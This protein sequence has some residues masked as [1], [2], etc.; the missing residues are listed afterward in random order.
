MAVDIWIIRECAKIG[1][2]SGECFAPICAHVSRRHVHSAL[3]SGPFRLHAGSI[4]ETIP[5]SFWNHSGLNLKM[6]VRLHS[7]TIM[8]SFESM[9]ASS[10]H[11]SD[12]ILKPLKPFRL[13]TGSIPET[14]P[15]SVSDYSGINLALF[16][17]RATFFLHSEVF[18]LD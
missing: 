1:S 13:H 12:V 16:A 10:W 18:D 17:Q 7:R 9:F 15:G 4:P 2:V 14:I 11:Y 8:G 6:N 3:S 5:G